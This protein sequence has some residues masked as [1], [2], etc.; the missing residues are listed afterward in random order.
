MDKSKKNTGGIQVFAAGAIW[1]TIGLFITQLDR[2]GSS[3]MMTSLLRVLF[4]FIIMAI[5][6]AVRSGFS[7]FKVDVRTLLSCALLG[8]ICH[9]VYNVFYSIAVVSAGVTISAVLLDIAPVFTAL[10]SRI[11]FSEKLTPIKILATAVN[12]IGCILAV[13]GGDISLAGL[14]VTGI[15]FGIGAGFCYSLT[16]IIGRIAGN[17]ADA[18]VISTYSYLFAAL[19]LML[20]IKP[21][22]VEISINSGIVIWGFLFALIPTSI[23]YIIYYKG[24]Q[25]IRESSKVPVYASIETI[26]AAV[27]GVLLLHESIGAVN[28]LGIVLVIAS[29]VLMNR[30]RKTID[31]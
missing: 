19:F 7:T 30:R 31:N 22:N 29:I 20:F 3:S 16:A 26:V 21:M 17:K 23:A 6:T 9:G 11:M 18:F 4:A 27:L 5:I 28:I 25:K 13:T 15:L 12:V 10:A 14:S 24:V 1:G 8:I 2:C